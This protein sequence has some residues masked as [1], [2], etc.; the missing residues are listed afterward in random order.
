MTTEKEIQIDLEIKSD[1]V[2]LIINVEK[3]KILT[4]RVKDFTNYINLQR[5]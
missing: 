3:T 2:D 5:L 1:E 4:Q